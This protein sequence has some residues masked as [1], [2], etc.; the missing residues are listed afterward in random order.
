QGGLAALQHAIHLLRERHA[1]V[2]LIGGV[3]SYKDIDTLHWLESLDRLKRDHQPHG[4]IP[5]EGS[6]FVLVCSKAFAQRYN[7][8]PLAEIVALSQAMEPNPW[9]MGHATQGQGLT[10]TLHELFD[11]V[12]P[13]YPKKADV[14]FCDLNGE[15]WRVDEWGYAYLRT[16]RYHGE[17]LAIRHP[18][19]CWGDVGAA[20]STLL[21][22][23]STYHLCHRHNLDRTALIWS[24]AD[25]RPWRAACLL[26][27]IEGAK[28]Q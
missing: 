14:V 3:D 1:P 20:T 23:L 7:L 26:Q 12:V 2:C 4:F 24:A 5:G 15:S 27:K 13:P 8:Q 18:A 9:Y 19:D 16:G 22:G 11:Q 17:P 21:L 28:I 25:T 10:Q 6:G